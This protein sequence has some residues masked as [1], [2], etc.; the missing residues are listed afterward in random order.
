VPESAEALPYFNAVVALELAGHAESARTSYRSGLE[1]WP[2]DRNL[3]MAY[4][5]L[6]Y[7]AGELSTAATS[8]RA[9]TQHH[10]SYAPAHN[11]LAQVLFEL[12]QL[13]QAL[14][15]ARTAVALGGDYS[16]TYQETIQ[17]ISAASAGPLT[18]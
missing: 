18:R 16:A 8:F 11:N 12:G 17:L 15:S 10:P 14:S 6:L 5:N 13:D 4:G 7:G 3:L 2:D 9:V 1:R